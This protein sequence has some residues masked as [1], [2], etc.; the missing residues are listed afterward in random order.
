MSPA[1]RLAVVLVAVAVLLGGL[2]IGQQ[3]GLGSGYSLAESEGKAKP[4]DY[5][6]GLNKEGFRLA[7]FDQFQE[8]VSR[9]V[10][11]EDRRPT[12][13]EEKPVEGTAVVSVVPDLDVTLTSII[14]TKDVKLAIVRDNKSSLSMVVR[15]GMPLEGEQSGWKLVEVDPRKAVF[16]GE[17][18]GRKELELSVN[19]SAT[20]AAPGAP[21]ASE[22]VTQQPSM[23]TSAPPAIAQNQ[24]ESDAANQAKAE[25]I[26]RRIEE[27]RRQLREEAERMRAQESSQ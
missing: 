1:R 2:L 24:A 4:R 15:L 3:F 13:I 16:E 11:N 5:L 27:R 18:S 23:N 9:P 17:G 12:P 26:R 22:S 19:E 8:L 14:H 21:P 7:G 6:G 10:F 25:E 20:Q